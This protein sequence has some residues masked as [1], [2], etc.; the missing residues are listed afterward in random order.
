MNRAALTLLAA[1]PLLTPASTSAKCRRAEVVPSMLTTRDTKLPADG[2]F[3]VGWTSTVDP[4]EDS[5][6]G[7][8]SDQPFVAKAG[9]QAVSL[10]RVALAPG[11]SAYYPVTFHGTLAVERPASKNRPAQ[12]FGT[13][14]RDADVKPMGMA[15]PAA[16]TVALT[17]DKTERWRSRHAV[18]TLSAAPPEAARALITYVTT[19]GKQAAV[20]FV[21]LPDTHDTEK[22]IEAFQDAGHCGFVVDGSHPPAAGDRVT[23]AW[24][25]AFGRL[26]PTS[27]AITAK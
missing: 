14:T 3:L 17:E 4:D 2:G 1:V 19:G 24:V 15:A 18:V 11:L 9:S 26:S 23:F 8:P 22:T 27:T 13:F 5:H 10:K 20:S 7:D 12:P 25:D 21:T 16:G 6:G